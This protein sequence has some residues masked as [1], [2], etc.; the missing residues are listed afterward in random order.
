MSPFIWVNAADC[1]LYSV[2][3]NNKDIWKCNDKVEVENI[4]YD[5]NKNIAGLSIR[6]INNKKSVFL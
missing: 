5:E 6:N 2:K 4:A 3:S 1:K